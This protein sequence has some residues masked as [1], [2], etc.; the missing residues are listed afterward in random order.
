MT[1]LADNNYREQPELKCCVDCK[2]GF[3]WNDTDELHC[4]VDNTIPTSKLPV[5]CATAVC[6]RYEVRQ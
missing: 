3:L 6:D 2:H 1:T 5:V 4:Y